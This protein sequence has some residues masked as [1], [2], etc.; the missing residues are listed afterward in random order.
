VT[1]AKNLAEAEESASRTF[2]AMDGRERA[3]RDVLVAVLK[4]KRQND[5][6]SNQ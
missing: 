3:Y 1:L 5:R 2:A 6:H 4:A